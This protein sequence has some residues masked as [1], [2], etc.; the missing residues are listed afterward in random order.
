VSNL[1]YDSS[2]QEKSLKFQ[3]I[4]GTIDRTLKNNTRNDTKL[5]FLKH[6]AHFNTVLKIGSQ[7]SRGA[8]MA[9][10]RWYGSS[11]N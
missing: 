2:I 7:N 5:K 4:C 6:K 11:E 9:F 10:L 3:S 1:E 8:E